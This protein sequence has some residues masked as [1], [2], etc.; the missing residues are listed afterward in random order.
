MIMP[1]PPFPALFKADVKIS[2]KIMYVHVFLYIIILSYILVGGFYLFKN[3][4]STGFLIYFIPVFIIA[5][6]AWSSMGIVRYR[7]QCI[8]Y[9][10]LLAAVGIE[11][12]K[13]Y[14]AFIKIFNIFIL[15]IAPIGYWVI[16][17]IKS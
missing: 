16:K 13:T 17:T 11:Q 14:G 1:Y 3:Y 6:T 9:F 15:L 5:I 8:P 4:K 7:E 2:D 12:R 10:A